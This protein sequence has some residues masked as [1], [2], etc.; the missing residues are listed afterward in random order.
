MSVAVIQAADEDP[1]RLEL[2]ARADNQQ[3]TARNQTAAESGGAATRPVL[4]A[5]SKSTLRVRWSIVNEGKTANVPD[6]TI[7]LVLEMLEEL[8]GQATLAAVSTK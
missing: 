7:H 8:V 4:T 3:Q 1:F 2:I 6:V 5:R